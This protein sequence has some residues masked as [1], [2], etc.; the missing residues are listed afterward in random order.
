MNDKQL[1][2]NLLRE[3]AEISVPQDHDPWQAMQARI[4]KD[5]LQIGR[6]SCRERV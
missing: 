4:Q 3:L 6:A 5:S 2:Q 1:K